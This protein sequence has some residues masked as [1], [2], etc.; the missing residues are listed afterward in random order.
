MPSRFSSVHKN[1]DPDDSDRS[2][3]IE[4]RCVEEAAELVLQGLRDHFKPTHPTRRAATKLDRGRTADGDLLPPIS[5]QNYRD[6][7]SIFDKMPEADQV[8]ALNGWSPEALV[9]DY[10][11]IQ[12]I[13]EEEALVPAL[14]L[15]ASDCHNDSS[16]RGEFSAIEAETVSA[17]T[18]FIRVGTTKRETLDALDQ[19]RDKIDGEW[20]RL[21]TA[22]D[23]PEHK[24]LSK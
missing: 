6:I 14:K 20:D 4:K 21:T 23:T 24:F 12:A 5:Q 17:V 2:T 9:P 3:A 11:E 18:M 10:S 22:P 7:L 8:R 15:R 19:L 1:P 16:A 13:F